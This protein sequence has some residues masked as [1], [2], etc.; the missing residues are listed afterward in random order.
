MV[1]ARLDAGLLKEHVRLD[2]RSE[3]VLIGA[4][5]RGA[6]SLRGEHGV[7]RVARTVADLDGSERV[8]VRH[9]EKALGLRGG[10]GVEDL[11]AV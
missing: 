10:G 8:E 3:G 2:E 1:N 6:L 11:I 5:E 4:R 7:L 9:L